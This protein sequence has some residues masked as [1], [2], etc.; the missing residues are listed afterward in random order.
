MQRTTKWS[1]TRPALVAGALGAAIAVPLLTFGSTTAEAG[2]GRLE[3]FRSCDDF[4]ALA[5]R[6]A[7]DQLDAGGG[8]AIPM[9]AAAEDARLGGAKQLHEQSAAT[10]AAGT[11]SATNV[12]VAGID[13]P[14]IVKT[15]GSRTF[16]IAQG[17]LYTLDTSTD[18]P[19]LVGSLTLPS[20]TFG[21]E[22]LLVGD[23]LMI[24]ADAP[25]AI[26]PGIGGP[27]V[28]SYGFPTAGATFIAVDVAD[29]AAPRVDET[30]T[31]DGSYVS[32]RQVGSTIRIV[33]SSNPLGRIGAGAATE[34]DYR[35]AIE[36]AQ[37]TDFIPTYTLRDA[38]GATSSG[39]LLACANISHP[40]HG[41]GV[42]M[43]S[44]LTVDLTS[45]IR[46]VDSDA[47][48]A[49]GWTVMASAAR[50]YVALSRTD[51]ENSMMVARTDVHAFDTSVANQTT[52]RASGTVLGSVLNQFAM[53][54][55]DG[56]LRIATTLES[57]PVTPIRAEPGVVTPDGD[58]TGAGEPGSSGSSGSSGSGSV[59]EAPDASTKKVIAPAPDDVV[60][61]VPV[62]VPPT[63]SAVSVLEEHG[64]ELTQVG[65]VAGLGRGERIYAVR[66]IGPTAYVVTFRQTDPLYTVDLSDPT[67]PRVAGALKIPGYSSYLHPIDDHTLIGIGQDVGSTPDG[68]GAIVRGLQV[69]LFDVS[70]PA[71][72]RRTRVW[73][74]PGASTEAEYDHHAF[75]WWPAT[76]TLV[77]P[78]NPRFAIEMDAADTGN[79]PTAIALRVDADA[80]TRTGLITHPAS[81]Q[82]QIRRTL[83]IN[84]RLLTFSDAG[85][86]ANSMDGATRTAWVPFE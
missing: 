5:R 84:D 69:G 7:I 38:G 22:M 3:P 62:Q 63:E 9:A 8:F 21:R 1:W 19:R 20:G 68:R 33:V 77:V 25:M 46:P 34:K 73:T 43:L 27:D 61:S 2:D 48:M 40:A 14:D 58:G 65:T 10:T 59:A 74:L 64:A 47:V 24:V 71:E 56:R 28:M 41:S 45:G 49:D 70:N 29:M 15:D 12:Q 26:E 16:A 57:Y 55:Y 76:R 79:R 82:T 83:V 30:L 18:K 86:A 35:A 75:L 80:I 37:A 54:E 66:F 23:R 17:R 11:F 36:S 44:I 31:V 52:Y 85:V 67:R 42:G 4:T 6:R 72:P 60:S 53:S 32:A 81:D 13:E 51:V 50:V 39:S 78:L